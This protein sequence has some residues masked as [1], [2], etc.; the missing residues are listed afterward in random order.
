MCDQIERA[1][2]LRCRSVSDFI[3]ASTLE[4]AQKVIATTEIIHLSRE[5]QIAIRN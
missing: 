1:V 3:V 4:A 2:A 5:A